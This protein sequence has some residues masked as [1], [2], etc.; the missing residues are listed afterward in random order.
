MQRT[1]EAVIVII[2]A[3]QYGCGGGPALV[4]EQFDEPTTLTWIAMDE[5][6]V[7]AR[8]VPR[9]SA[10][11]RDYVFLGPVEVNRMGELEYYLWVGAASTVDRPLYG[12]TAPVSASLLVEA[13][14]A[15]LSLPLTDGSPAIDA[16]PYGVNVPIERTQHARITLDQVRRLADA[17][18][19][20]VS[21]LLDSGTL[22]PYTLWRGD[23]LRWK[24]FVIARQSAGR[25]L[26]RR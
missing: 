18:S 11:A 5:P 4:P 16:V 3:T 14:G 13:D 25:R 1:S 10:S 23:W 8:R 2:L 22:V 21:V 24:Q 17:G 12:E 7:L 9:Y 20:E 19:V 26:S 15:P 6:I